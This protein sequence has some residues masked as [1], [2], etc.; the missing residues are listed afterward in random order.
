VRGPVV[1]S[2]AV[3]KLIALLS[4][5]ALAVPA[6]ALAQDPERYKPYYS[7]F[8]RGGAKIP[9]HDTR[10]VPQGLAYWPQRDAL[11]ISY[12]DGEHEK[13]SRL[14]AIDRASGKRLQLYELHDDGH[15]GALAIAG[16][17]LWVGDSGTL[18]RFD[19]S[20]L[21]ATGE[22]PRIEPSANFDV[23]ASSFATV[24]GDKL[25]LG[26]FNRGAASAAYR[27]A[28][29]AEG[30]LAYDGT[31]IHAP[32]QAQGLAIAGGTAIWSRSFGRDNDSRIDIG[33]LGADTFP[34]SIVAPSMVEGMVIAQGELHVLY[35]SGSAVYAD[36]D[37]RVKTVH[38]GPIGK[39]LA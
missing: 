1:L 35:E 24:E 9:G 26:D 12:Y 2:M 18:H 3:R 23:K 5:L 13:N 14:A 25:W 11:L 31:R 34:R 37:Y 32:S 38:H 10:W 19:L 36:A 17:Y 6:V 29:D 28:V 22:L 33:P 15:V 21:D 39:V 16:P 30:D 27:Y 20:V 7:I 8:E 4:L